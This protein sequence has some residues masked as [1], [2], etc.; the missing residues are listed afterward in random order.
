[1]WQQ[2]MLPSGSGVAVGAVIAVPHNTGVKE[3]QE[4]ESTSVAFLY[5]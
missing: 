1:M 2:P 5:C 4:P 3:I